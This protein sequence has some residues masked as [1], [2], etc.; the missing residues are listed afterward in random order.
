MGAELGYPTINL[1]IN[2][3]YKL[4][5]SNGVY[6]AIVDFEGERFGAMLNIGDNPTF[7]DKKW[8]IEA[9]IFE[10]SKT[11][12]N[13]RVKISFIQRLRDEIKFSSTAELKSQMENDERNAKKIID[14]L[15]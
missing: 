13:Q 1:A 14:T 12:Y 9:H 6:A 3:E 4:I 10:F 11:I 8:S 5:P 7:S 15:K 2:S